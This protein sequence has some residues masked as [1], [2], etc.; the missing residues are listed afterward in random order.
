MDEE[1]ICPVMSTGSKMTKCLKGSC[2]LWLEFQGQGN[3]TF[4]DRRRFFKELH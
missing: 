1:K 4:A 3:C 2:A